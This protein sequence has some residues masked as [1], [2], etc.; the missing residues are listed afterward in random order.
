M[1]ILM[2]TIY[3][4]IKVM[5]PSAPD[6]GLYLWPVHSVTNLLLFQ[7]YGGV[8]PAGGGGVS[9]DEVFNFEPDGFYAPTRPPRPYKPNRQE[10]YRPPHPAHLGRTRS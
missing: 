9:F 2:R 8:S 1:H 5:T 6:K 7:A 4:W 10:F 3:I